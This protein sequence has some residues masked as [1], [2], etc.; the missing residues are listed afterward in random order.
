[1]KHTEI[2]LIFISFISIVPTK[3]HII[4]ITIILIIIIIITIIII[5]IIII[6]II[7]AVPLTVRVRGTADSSNLSI[8]QSICLSISCHW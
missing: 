7:T 2:P 4:I 3:V 1:M 8:Y 6:I 5:T